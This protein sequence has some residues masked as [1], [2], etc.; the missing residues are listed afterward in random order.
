MGQ[1]A[2]AF[3]A[4]GGHRGQNPPL[5]SGN[6]GASL[7]SVAPLFLGFLRRARSGSRCVLDKWTRQINVTDKTYLV[8]PVQLPIAAAGVP[9]H[10][11]HQRLCT[12][13]YA[14]N[15]GSQSTWGSIFF[16]G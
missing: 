11:M 13:N 12:L 5:D 9:S 2:R 15:H 16:G 1:L 7:S 4:F 14:R 8:G 6:R 10:N 3:G